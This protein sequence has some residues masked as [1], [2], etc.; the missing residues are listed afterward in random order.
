[1]L[2]W[3]VFLVKC[4]LVESGTWGRVIL[5]TI[6]LS[7]G[8]YVFDTAQL[9]VVHSAAFWLG[10]SVAVTCRVSLYLLNA[11]ANWIWA[12][13]SEVEIASLIADHVCV[14]LSDRFGLRPPIDVATQ[15]TGAVLLLGIGVDVAGV[16][17]V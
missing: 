14:D 15:P 5:C 9:A 10:V 3:Q 1:M 4:S 11:F 13:G 12:A 17:F 2:L 8:R 16:H 6:G 7:K